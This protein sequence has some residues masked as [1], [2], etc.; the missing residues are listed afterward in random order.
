MSKKK[1]TFE[2][3]KEKNER[4]KKYLTKKNKKWKIIFLNVINK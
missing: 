2:N 1:E 3:N 4:N